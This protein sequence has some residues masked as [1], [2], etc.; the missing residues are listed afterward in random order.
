MKTINEILFELNARPASTEQILREWA[1][2]IIDEC[3]ERTVF[4]KQE[5]HGVDLVWLTES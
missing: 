1:H 2:G 5:Y 3:A 4:S